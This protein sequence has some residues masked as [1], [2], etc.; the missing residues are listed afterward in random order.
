M[1]NGYFP[2]S[3]G[4]AP[5]SAQRAL[6]LSISSELLKAIYSFVV[7]MMVAFLCRVASVNRLTTISPFMSCFGCMIVLRDRTE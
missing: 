1:S 6:A 2:W 3:P 7:G 4:E 5:Q